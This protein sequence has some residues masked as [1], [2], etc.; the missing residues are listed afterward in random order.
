[1]KKIKAVSLVKAIHRRAA[2]ASVHANSHFVFQQ[3]DG[4]LRE[5]WGVVCYAVFTSRSGI[6][7]AR[8]FINQYKGTHKSPKERKLYNKFIHWVVNDS[9]WEKAF[10]NKKADYFKDGFSMNCA[11]PHV[12]VTGA[13]N[14]IR[15]AHEF[16]HTPEVF[17]TLCK[18]GVSPE[19]SHMVAGI[20]QVRASLCLYGRGSGHCL[21]STPTQQDLKC[22]KERIIPPSP[23]MNKVS[24]S[25]RGIQALF[26]V[27]I[28]NGDKFISSILNPHTTEKVVGNWGDSY[29]LLD[30]NNPA[31][32]QA[33][34]EIDN[35]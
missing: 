13:M 26:K 29:K 17:N 21:F 1:M 23:P 19:L 9:P 10:L 15:E 3:G 12:Y 24:D 14:A 20:T 4:Q 22:Y 11:M 34:K 8:L 16:P 2:A 27:K 33:L 5:Y 18:A 31:V 25:Y 32:I 7:K 28:K 6:I 35:E 30:I